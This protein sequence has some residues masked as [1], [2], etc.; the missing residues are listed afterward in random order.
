MS[1]TAIEIIS[2]PGLGEIEEPI[3]GRRFYVTATIGRRSS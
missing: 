1:R 3:P 2:F